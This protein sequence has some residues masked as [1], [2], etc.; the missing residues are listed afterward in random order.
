MKMCIPRERVWKKVHLMH[1][2]RPVVLSVVKS[3]GR[4]GGM[5]EPATLRGISCT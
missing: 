1:L 2:V 5:P 3:T 4:R